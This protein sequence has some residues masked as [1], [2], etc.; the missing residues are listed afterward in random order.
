MMRWLA[1]VLGVVVCSCCSCRSGA[2]TVSEARA[3]VPLQGVAVVELFTSEGCSSCPRADDVL[4]ELARSGDARIYPLAFHVDYW[5]GL[6]WADRFASPE[7]T[8]R[9]RRY[10]RALGAQ[11]LYTPQM[12]V[13]GLEEF[14]GSDGERAK[15]AVAHALAHPPAVRLSLHAHWT[16]PDAVTVDYEALGAPPRSEVTVAVVERAASTAVRRGENAGRVLSHA[17]VV[18]GFVSRPMG[19]P[20]DSVTAHVSVP[21]DGDLEVTAF[22]QRADPT[23]GM[24]ILGAARAPLKAP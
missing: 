8:A 13:G 21:P 6:G 23:G 9:Q 10:A 5:D 15:A 18:L 7:N 3:D 1:G 20:A 19:S 12:V 22:V 2:P 4:A 16:G 14:V 11:G 24:P 17:D